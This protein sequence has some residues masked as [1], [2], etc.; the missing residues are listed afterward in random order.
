MTAGDDGEWE[1]DGPVDTRDLPALWHCI[2]G[3]NG[4]RGERAKADEEGKPKATQDTRYFD[5]R[6]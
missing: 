5:L 2:S 6:R 4:N 3:K 1:D